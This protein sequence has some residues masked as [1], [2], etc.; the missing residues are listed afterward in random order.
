MTE[1]NDPKPDT[2]YTLSF[3][4]KAGSYEAGPFVFENGRWVHESNRGVGAAG[5]IVAW[6][7]AA[8][9]RGGE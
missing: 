7:E 6:V 4:D 5:K 1:S 8:P 3:I 9:V 2:P